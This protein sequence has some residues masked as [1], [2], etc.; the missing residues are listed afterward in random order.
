M[1]RINRN[2][3]PF[4]IRS[5]ITIIVSIIT[6]TSHDIHSPIAE[7]AEFVCKQQG[8]EPPKI[9]LANRVHR[10]HMPEI[11]GEHPWIGDIP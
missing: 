10:S 8:R 3:Y 9:K 2:G 11:F 5:D 6:G 7:Q 1:N 4:L